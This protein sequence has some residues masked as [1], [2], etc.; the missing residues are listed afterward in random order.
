MRRIAEGLGGDVETLRVDD[1]FAHVALLRSANTASLPVS[2][3]AGEA[4]GTEPL[5]HTAEQP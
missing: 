5:G 1:A 2:L 4:N 3:R